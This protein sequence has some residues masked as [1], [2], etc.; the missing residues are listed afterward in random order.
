MSYQEGLSICMAFTGL[1]VGL[2]AAWVFLD[3]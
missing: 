1:V 3:W 2:L